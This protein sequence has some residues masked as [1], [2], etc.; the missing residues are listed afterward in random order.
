MQNCQEKEFFILLLQGRSVQEDFCI[1]RNQDFNAI[2]E[3]MARDINNAERF[4]QE[5]GER[6][7]SMW[8]KLSWSKFLSNVESLEQ[9]DRLKTEG[10]IFILF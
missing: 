10:S 6:M 1:S 9:S 3:G 4:S 5:V 7:T 8:P 2:N